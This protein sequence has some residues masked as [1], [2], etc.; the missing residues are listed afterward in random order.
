MQQW[1][2]QYSTG[3][4]NETTGE[5]DVTAGQKALVVSILSAGT[6]FGSLIAAPA[7]DKIGRRWGL[8]CSC[9]LFIIGVVLQVVSVSMPLFVVGRGIAGFGVGMLST[10][11]PLYQSEMLVA[12]SLPF[13]ITERRLTSH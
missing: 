5:P 9:T 4:V 2:N 6:F 10:L 1:K 8:I 12:C 13:T 11:I 3:Y 7:G